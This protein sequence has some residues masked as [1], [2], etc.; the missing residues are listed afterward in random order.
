MWLGWQ[1]DRQQAPQ[2]KDAAA[3]AGIGALAG[4]EAGPAGVLSGAAIG[5]V[6]SMIGSAVSGAVSRGFEQGG[7]SSSQPAGPPSTYVPGG[8]QVSGQQR[9]QEAINR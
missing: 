1:L 2:H 9:S 5:A 8:L 6:G 3:A 7:G 4:A